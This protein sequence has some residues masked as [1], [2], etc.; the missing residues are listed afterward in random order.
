[1][2]PLVSKEAREKYF[3]F[4]EVAKKEKAETLYR[5]KEA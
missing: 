3:Y 4:L 1:M 5:G 2:G